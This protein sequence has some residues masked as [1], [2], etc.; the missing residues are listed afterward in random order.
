[1]L[2]YRVTSFSDVSRT[3]RDFGATHLVSLVDPDMD[4]PLTPDTISHHLVLKMHDVDHDRNLPGTP[5]DAQVADLIAFARA[6]PADARVAFH[7]VAGRRRSTAAALICDLATGPAAT[8]DRIDA[9]WQRLRNARPDAD[10]NRA[11]LRIA[12]SQLR[13]GGALR[14]LRVVRH[15]TLDQHAKD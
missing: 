15:M 13:L 14:D 7:C 5:Q 3:I 6:L 2:T 12:D 9:A 8:P 11:L 10:P 1:M 4:A